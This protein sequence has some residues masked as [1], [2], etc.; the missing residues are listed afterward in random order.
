MMRKGTTLAGLKKVIALLLLIAIVTTSVQLEALA[1]GNVQEVSA[2][3]T[4][5]PEVT[6]KEVQSS[7]EP[8]VVAELEEE[9]TQNSNTFLLDNGMKQIVLYSDDIRYEDEEGN[10]VDYNPKLVET[11]TDSMDTI[12]EL[13][14]DSE[15]IDQS[16]AADYIYENKSGDSKQ[17][18]P[19]TIDSDTPLLMTNKDYKLTFAPLTESKNDTAGNAFNNISF[20][21]VRIEEDLVTDSYG[22]EKEVPIQAVYENA[23]QSIALEYRSLDFGIKENII[24][25]EMPSSNTFSFIME[26]E[27]M[28][29]KLDNPE[30]GG[31]I[32]FFDEET[33]TIVG[34]IEAPFMNDATEE[35]YSE[36]LHY[37]ITKNGEKE[38]VYILTLVVD[39]NYLS[40]SD[41]VYPVSI[42][43]TATWTGSSTILDSYVL[44]AQP[45]Y[46][47]YTSSVT[48]FSVGTGTQGL[49]R[50][51][52][53]I[54]GFG[55]AISGMYVES[56][57][58]TVYE[59]GANASGT[60]IQAKQV[61]ETFDESAITWNTKPANASTVYASI[62]S[63]GVTGT[64]KT[65][66][67][68]TWAQGMANG[69]LAKKGLVLMASSESAASTFVRFYGS[70]A[71]DTAK[72]PKLVATYYDGPT[73]ATSVTVDKYYLK[74]GES[75]TVNW[76]GITSQALSYV[77][78]RVVPFD[79]AT[80]TLK[81]TYIV[82]ST[83]TKVGTTGSGSSSISASTGWPEGKYKIYLRG[84]DK[85]GIVG[86]GAGANFII[87]RT[88]P[89]IK[90]TSLS[91]A[92][93]EASYSKT[94]PTLTWDVT[95]KYL[96]Q[97]QVSINGGAYT[98]VGTTNSGSKALSGLASGQANTIHVRA[99]DKAGNYSAVKSYTYYYD[100]T[101]P[102]INSLTI[103]PVTSSTVYS[104][105]TSPYVSWN[106]SEPTLS[107]VQYSV[108]GGSY[109][110]TTL[111]LSGSLR[112]PNSLF[113][114]QG[115]Y[116]VK[117]KATDKAGNTAEKSVI[118][119]YYSAAAFIPAN[120]SV[121]EQISGS[122]YVRWSIPDDINDIPGNVYYEVHRGTTEDFVVSG[123]TLAADNVRQTYCVIDNT[124]YGR[125]Y[126]YK[127][128]LVRKNS[129]GEKTYEPFSYVAKS[130][131]LK[132]D[133]YQNRIGSKSYYD[134]QSFDLPNGNGM[135]EK[136]GGNFMYS[137]SD[138][139]LPNA[140]L[141]LSME[142]TYNSLSSGR[143]IFGYG[144]TFA[145]DYK[146]S[147]RPNGDILLQDEKGSIYTF[148]LKS[149][150]SYSCE[151]GKDMTLTVSEEEGIAYVVTILQSTSYHFTPNGK[152]SFIRDSNGNSLTLTYDSRYEQLSKVTSSSGK[153]M[154]FEY[155]DLAGTQSYPLVK[156]IK[157]PDGSS[158]AYAYQEDRLTK[159]SHI[160]TNGGIIDYTYQYSS[161]DGQLSTVIDA[162]G[163][164]YDIYYTNGKVTSLKYPDG[165]II[166]LSYDTSTSKTSITKYNTSGAVLYTESTV[167]DTDGKAIEYTDVYGNL[168]TYQY[169]GYLLTDT[170]TNV[171]YQYIDGKVI[172][173]DT[174][175]KV[176]KATYDTATDN[177]KE[178]VDEN[179]NK[180]TY[181]YTDKNNPNLVTKIV[182][183]NKKTD[184]ADGEEP[185]Y[186]TVE[187]VEYTY[188]SKGNQ[189]TETDFIN[190][191][192]TTNTYD[193]LGNQLTSE[194]V[195]IAVTENGDTDELLDVENETNEYDEDGNLTSTE[196][197]AGTIEEAVTY[198]YD[199]MGKTLQSNDKTLDIITAYEYDEFG[200]QIKTTVT[201]SD[202]SNETTTQKYDANGTMTEETDRAGRVTTYQYDN[203]NRLTNKNLSYHS[204]NANGT[205]TNETIA[206]TT[207][208]FYET[209]AVNTG[210]T[211]KQTIQNAYAELN[212][213]QYSKDDVLIREGIISKSYYDGKGQIVREK[214][215]G[216]YV[217]Y[218]YDN[219][220]KAL[221][222]Y[223]IGVSESNEDGA[224]TLNIYD[225]KGNVTHTIMNPVYSGAEQAFTIDSE[226]TI[227]TSS[228]YDN[229]GNIV[230]TTD[231]KGNV[232]QY[233]YDNAKLIKLEAT[234]GEIS[235]TQQTYLYDIPNKDASG[236]VISTSSQTV[237][238]L[239]NISETVENGAGQTLSIIDA[240][241][242]QNDSQK[243]VTS[244]EYDNTGNKVKEIYSNNSY[245]TFTYDGR[246]RLVST[247]DYT[248]S[249]EKTLE[250]V[251]TYDNHDKL[252]QSIDFKF[253]DGVKAALCNTIYEYDALD[254]MTAFAQIYDKENPSE[255]E[256]S[257]SKISYRYD[258]EGKLESITYPESDNLLKGLSYGYNA[259]GWITSIHAVVLINGEET[260]RPVREYTYHTDGKLKSLKDYTNPLVNSDSYILKEYTYDVFDR[261]TSMTYTNSN[262]LDTVMESH[263]YEYD[264]NSNI[265][266]ETNINNY[267]A[268]DS[269]KVNE[270]R[271]YEY[272][273]LGQLLK[274]VLTDHNSGAVSET[275]YTYDKVG[276]RLT[277]TEGNKITRY[278]Y[279][280]LNQL[281]AV[282]ETTDGTVTSQKSY[283]HDANGNQ[284]LVT[285]TIK[286]E[287]ITSR[288][289]VENR[290]TK[291]MIE[292][293]SQVVL[294]QENEY[295]G[296]G[297]RIKKTDNDV[298]T[299]YY[300][301][302]SILLYTTDEDGNQTS[303]NIIGLEDNIIATVRTDIAASR[304][305]YYVYTK[306]IKGST[307]NIVDSL[308]NGIVSYEYTDFGE[309]TKK[310]NTG[311]YNE[312]CYTGGVY[313]ESTGFYYL[314]ARY[315]NPED[316]RFLTQDTY[317]G[318]KDKIGTWHLYAYCN[319][320]PIN[321]VDPS[322]HKSIKKTVW[323]YF[324]GKNFTKVQVAGIMG[325]AMQE[326][327]WNPLRRSSG[328]QYWGLF[329]VGKSN[330][331][332]LE[333]KYKAAGL[334]M[335]KYGYNVSTYQG[336]G[337]EKNIPKKDLSK[338]LNCQL[339]FIYTCKPSGPDWVSPLK[340]AKTVNEAAEI[341]LVKFEGAV[342]SS[343][344]E[345]NKIKYYSAYKG[346]YFQET[347]KRRKY[348]VKYYNK[349]A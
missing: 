187:H 37:E 88:V 63:S 261:V 209:V 246:N 106:I 87:D 124:D 111:A 38:N 184:T 82:Y 139:T 250:T 115:T 17:Y 271:T 269:E 159:V 348:A 46:N 266:K 64:A 215:D 156:Q 78:Y 237:D 217:D 326:S 263:Q 235:L 104:T 249:N 70:R 140:Q 22:V 176:T 97:V 21:S 347:D 270:S 134:Y 12:K 142:R 234:D 172:K 76:A 274:S 334:N 5:Q 202:G 213:Y 143:T 99:M 171:V 86:T 89:V 30:I 93:S 145:Y 230:T 183:E 13:A 34:G 256:I 48:T 264:K 203:R 61:T 113:P 304:N 300:Y 123:N 324:R 138:F 299:N 253:T 298:V 341:F 316:G 239:G 195:S 133:A 248:S 74:S 309:T 4:V 247:A 291:V 262:D 302:G 254:R 224:L 221:T 208:Y 196:S 158:F 194:T 251:Y 272:D 40:S 157:L 33:N 53:K 214:K 90:S 312:I 1:E 282:T 173:E 306:D 24:L 77:Q 222:T 225:E 110:T 50:T 200:R 201:Y 151:E 168:T 328:S 85:G 141:D 16:T 268:Q 275:A 65:F 54:S 331:L 339:K 327:G 11:D 301:S 283:L 180:T 165:E 146:L 91:I 119:Y 96:S 207:K 322:G 199:A 39:Q 163:N 25:N 219:N 174:K 67:L 259:D 311:F 79:E 314:N 75:L 325:N 204:I 296:D 62:T 257:K 260:L 179:G 343:N 150:G 178:E 152:L 73:T 102:V 42:D 310:G 160:G 286:N 45:T 185:E 100:N 130:I 258:I 2:E 188:D 285:D 120:I 9:R 233:T 14:A 170:V 135:V 144:W 287:V 59:N 36:D 26:M 7:G 193:S 181:E 220:G 58:L 162:V 131:T 155:Y 60:V 19:K 226:D 320:N 321:Y 167:Y 267:P 333:K 72:R 112:L 55:T 29:P 307:I 336:S 103:N 109:T 313:D 116:T 189:L 147:K 154:D 288:Y 68:T 51:Y 166:G 107:S 279:N 211:Q 47:Y 236:T 297:Q 52:M 197:E 337:A 206:Y 292:K 198:T 57:K 132:K 169:N 164:Q 66:D 69:S 344:T 232:I 335:K 329:Q 128:R 290:L 6:S 212:E 83:S 318:E 277:E 98:S 276:N 92:T 137:Q 8:L 117:I 241:T 149:D 126:Y 273:G 10:L 56:A 49:F 148:T 27:G 101:A 121:E 114:K 41:R 281:T 293:D 43:P 84:V 216:L 330:A 338:I 20:G 315:Y 284:I 191:T 18:I 231:A 71:S 218:T 228:T 294:F 242:N 182:K 289:D 95:E 125:T 223:V 345:K 295:N 23:E 177:I 28:Y 31:G 94:L 332:K 32:T 161:A 317:R 280:H 240:G 319:G 192:K 229:D 105:E 175:Q 81:D 265:T 252:I 245:K 136:S 303:R 80:D 3:E 243:I 278:T 323:D 255:D 129:S 349:Y 308:G 342:S 15:V 122:T 205:G 340:K 153:T 210:K 118:Y 227:I 305:N 244:Y 127:V 108:N 346:K 190:N 186:E 44:K 238:A 35:A